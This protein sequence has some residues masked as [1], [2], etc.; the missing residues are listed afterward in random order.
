MTPWS[1]G[2]EP[3]TFEPSWLEPP[4]LNRRGSTPRALTL[5][6]QAP[7]NQTSCS[8]EGHA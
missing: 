8:H 6:R 2:L 1:F 3:P 7:V 4:G 5:V